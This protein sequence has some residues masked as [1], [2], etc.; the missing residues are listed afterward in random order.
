MPCQYQPGSSVT[1]VASLYVETYFQKKLDAPSCQC[2]KLRSH[3][4]S[5]TLR[6]NCLDPF[7]KKILKKKLRQTLNGCA[8]P[9]PQSA[10]NLLNQ[11]CNML[12]LHQA[13]DT[14][15]TPGVGLQSRRAP[16]RHCPLDTCIPPKGHTSCAPLMSRN[17]TN[18]LRIV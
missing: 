10:V 5:P 13:H 11:G 3:C 17:V 4:Y 14:A 1:T 6:S 7:F 9:A 12:A 2:S 8:P 18:L 15:S 16:H